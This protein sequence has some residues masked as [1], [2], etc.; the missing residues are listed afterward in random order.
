M[1]A[2]VTTQVG[3]LMNGFRYGYSVYQAEYSRNLLFRS[4]AQMEDLFDRVLDRVR[5]RLDIPAIRTIFGLKSRPHRSRKDGPP[6][7]EIVIE[8][9]RYGFSWFRITFGRLQIKACTKGEHVLGFEATVHNT[10]ELRCRHGLDNFDQIITRLAGMAGRFAA[11]LDCADTGFLPDGILDE[12]PAA[13]PGR[14][15]QDRRIDLNKPRIR[16]AL[17][18]RQEPPL[19]RP[20]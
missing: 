10:K 2:L 1:S 19:P 5:S 14:H 15:A 13:R 20:A 11:A 17:A 18:A 7:Q 4:G 16:A 9:P 12:L 3:R 8:K 6:A